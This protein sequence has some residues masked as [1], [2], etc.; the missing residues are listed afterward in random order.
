MKGISQCYKY[1][2]ENFNGIDVS[3]RV[4]NQG[5]EVIILIPVCQF[6]K[7]SNYTFNL[8]Y[9]SSSTIDIGLGKGVVTNYNFTI[10]SVS[11]YYTLT[12]PQGTTYNLYNTSGS[13][14][15]D[16]GNRYLLDDA[17]DITLMLWRRTIFLTR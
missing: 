1:L 5:N 7:N 13:E 10:S 11:N 17:C 12:S 15:K 2:S 3:S 9:N 16:N 14:Y 8:C 6:M 4:T